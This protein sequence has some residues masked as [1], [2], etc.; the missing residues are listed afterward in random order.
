MIPSRETQLQSLKNEM[1]DLLIIGGG[2]TGSG[3]A[4][5]AVTRGYKVALVEAEDFASGT[6]SRSTK[7]IHGGVRYLE[8]AVKHLDFKQFKLV[9]NSLRERSILL[10]I[11]PHLTSILPIFTPAYGFW[12]KLYYGLGMKLYD[13][14]SGSSSLKSSRFI[15]T[16]ESL[17]LFPNLKKENLKGGIVYYDGQFDDARMNISLILTAISH[18][19]VITNY[20]PVIKINKKNREINS[21]TVKEQFTGKEWEV[22]ARVFVNAAGPFVD[23]IRRL[24]DPR[25]PPIVKGS[26]G[27]HILL[28]REHCPKDT[29]FLIPKTSD[30]RVLFLLP[31]EGSTLL[32]T[33]DIPTEISHDPKPSETEIEYLLDHLNKYLTQ[34]ISKEEIKSSWCG[35]RPLLREM[36]ETSTANLIRDYQ[37]VTSSSKLYS[38]MGG[39]WTTYRKM[40]SDLL[41]TI[42]RNQ[43]LPLK[44]PCV[45]ENTRLIGANQKFK[46]N[47]N[48]LEEDVVSHL[49]HSYGDRANKIIH[50]AQQ[51]YTKRLAEG[52]PYIEAEVIYAMQEE[53]ACTEMDILERRTRLKTLDQKAAETAFPRVSELL[54]RERG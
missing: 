14:I 8:Y 15:S 20:L 5:D 52:Y 26:A 17:K 43:D 1:F 41:D 21:V 19:A 45:T 24:D 47:K 44:G 13:L 16:E 2:A 10:K 27:S 22:K 51:G 6:S 31:W 23:E 38:I 42:I 30:G 35:I 53:Y 46:L 48:D 34:P 50:I 33:T 4:L 9:W 39:K 36:N 37:I 11:A 49:I 25:L 54:L 40:G 12:E 18:G 32:G 29:G 3:V 28:N 7:L